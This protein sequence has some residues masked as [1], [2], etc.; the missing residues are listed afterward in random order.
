MENLVAP[1]GTGSSQMKPGVRLRGPINEFLTRHRQSGI[2]LLVVGTT[3]FMA[4]RLAWLV[5][6]YAVDLLYFDEWDVWE[7]M[8]KQADVWTLWRFQ[9]GPQRQG[10]AQWIMATVAWAFDWNIRAEAFTATV[11]IVLATAVGLAMARSLRGRWSASDCLIPIALLSVSL[12][13]VATVVPNLSHGPLPMLLVMTCAYFAQA[14]N[15]RTRAIGIAVTLAIS[16]QTGF[17]WFLAIVAIPLLLVLLIGAVRSGRSAT[18][19][20]LGLGLVIASLAVFFYG[21]RFVPAVACFQ[22]PAP[23]PWRYL[24]FIG[25]MVQRL[26]AFTIVEGR[27]LGIL[28]AI[29]GLSLAMWSGW[30]TLASAGKDRLASSVFVLSAFS[31]TFA[32]NTAV[33]RLCLGE[34]AGTAG[35]YVPYMLPLVMAAYLFLSLRPGFPRLRQIVIVGCFAFA[36][37][38]ETVL[39][40][41]ALAEPDYHTRIKASFRECYLDTARLAACSA[42]WPIHPDPQ[43]TKLQEKLDYLRDHR[44]SLFRTMAK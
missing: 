44:L 41:S 16:I 12:V 37:V 31:L 23:K 36:A 9:W 3:A 40:S 4:V 33:G 29:L 20:A 10:L 17:A 15:E 5:S 21:Y 22:F 27:P 26:L 2:A 8:F 43:G 32:A 42:N 18:Y 14:R 6:H 24:S 1:A 19:H 39:V 13:S 38:K 25:V 30:T 28:G 7:G 34:E 11:I 35:R